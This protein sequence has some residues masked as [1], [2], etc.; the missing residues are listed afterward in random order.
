LS[1]HKAAATALSTAIA[2]YQGA[3]D[4]FD[5]ETARMLGINETDLRCLELLLRDEAD[6][7]PRVLADRLNLTTGSVT[8]MLDRLERLHYVTRTA[9]PSDRRKVIVTATEDAGRK[10][11]ALIDPLVDEGAQLLADYDTGQLEFIAEFLRRTTALQQRHTE[12]VRGL[13]TP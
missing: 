5:R 1:S 9:H 10:A 6:L 13:S 2:N 12:R 4:D 8:T 11:Y 3:V 7:T